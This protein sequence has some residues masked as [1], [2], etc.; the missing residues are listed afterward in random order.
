MIRLGDCARYYKVRKPDSDW[1]CYEDFKVVSPYELTI[2]LMTDYPYEYIGEKT[3][4]FFDY[5]EKSED[6]EYVCRKRKEIR[7]RLCEHRMSYNEGFV[8]TESETNPHKVSFHVIFKKIN[9]VRKHFIKEDEYDL[10]CKLVGKENFVN[11][12]HHVYGSQCCFRLPFGTKGCQG[13]SD[14]EHAHVPFN[15]NYESVVLSDYSLTIPDDAET[16]FYGMQLGRM[17]QKQCEEDQRTYSNYIPENINEDSR[18]VE[19]LRLVKPERFKVYSTWCALMTILKTHKQPV[20]LFIELSEK[21]GYKRF[22]ELE[23]RKKWRQCKEN[24]SFGIPTI[25]GWLKQDGVDIKQFKTHTILKD[26]VKIWNTQLEFTDLQ[27]ALCLHKYY[28]DNLIYTGQGWFHYTD[29]WKLGDSSS[30]F[31]PVMKF[32]SNDLSKHIHQKRF[33]CQEDEKQDKKALMNML[34]AANKLESASKIKSILEVAQGIFRDDSAFDTFDNKPHWFCFDNQKAFDL[35]ENKVVDIIATDRILTTCGYD[36]PADTQD[37]KEL[38]E[39]M[40]KELVPTESYK[41]LISSMSLFTY[42]E[43]INESLIIYKGEGRNGKGMTM[44]LLKKTLGNYYYDLPS[45]VLTEHSKGDG[46]AKPELAQCRW[47]RC[48]MFSEPDA[49]KNIVKTTINTLTGRDTITVRQLH[50]EPFSYMPKFVLAGMCNDIPK[51]SGG[52][53]DSIKMRMKHQLFPY[54]FIEEPT[55]DT[56]ERKADIRLKEQVRC[57]NR[58]RDGL[59]WLL[60]NTWVENQGKYVSCESDLVERQAYEKENNPVLD[61]LEYYEPSAE[62][63]RIKDLYKTFK[64][65]FGGKITN[66][67]FKRFL[68]DAKVKMQEDKKNGD[69]VFLK[70]K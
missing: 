38:V 67:Q 14:K 6:L 49:G 59:L 40:L 7:D 51:V 42:G 24:E 10:F 54:T 46:R 64:E 57:D 65:D 37:N 8:F 56:N 60:L 44:T 1:H 3:K 48:V 36:L 11:I 21:S 34:K 39:T 5:D 55:P 25:M 20:D 23:C 66:Q 50:K 43:N 68:V 47:A 16:K 28:K 4:L 63:I 52:I 22:D 58:F 31:A 26:L 15:L 70:R 35:K 41:S 62:V 45:E 9:I 53:G 13:H 18:L 30:I 61:W 33:S 17:M 32:L 12:D 27:I 2:E 69:K 29:Q 19:M